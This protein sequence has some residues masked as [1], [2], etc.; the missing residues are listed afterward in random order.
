M[1]K[2]SDSPFQNAKACIGMILQRKIFSESK[3]NIALVLCGTSETDNQLAR[4]NKNEYLNISVQYNLQT[5]SWDLLQYIQNIEGTSITA[6]YIDA[7]VVAMDILAEQTK[8]QK[9]ASQ[10]ILIFSNFGEDASND[11][12]DVIIKGI[13]NS[14]MQ[15][16]IISPHNFFDDDESDDDHSTD[17]IKPVQQLKGKALIRSMLKEVQ[18]E[19]YSFSDALP[20]L[21]Y[22]QKKAVQPA[23]W[24]AMLEISSSFK[25]PITGYVKITQ[26]K[27]GKRWDTVF[28]LDPNVNIIRETS[29]HMND[30]AQT[31]IKKEDI[32]AGYRYGTT[33][34]PFSEEDKANMAYKSSEKGIKVLGFTKEDNIKYHHYIGDKVIYIVG[35]KTNES[36]E[37]ALSAFIQALYET[38]MV[39]VVR[40]VYSANSPPKLG[41][42]SPR[43]KKEYECLVF[44]QL[45][46]M[47][48]LRHYTFSSLDANAKNLPTDEQTSI[49]DKLITEMDLSIVTNDDGT[50]EEELFK[51]SQ[52]IN[53]YLQRYFQ[54]LQHRALKPE[55]SLPPMPPY[56]KNIFKVPDK[57]TDATKPI[58]EKIKKLFP[59]EEVVP[60]KSMKTG[61]S[62][63][64]NGEKSEEPPI[65]RS[66]SGSDILQGGMAE[67]VMGN[68]QEVGTV[69][70]L[71]DFKKLISNP[72]CNFSEVC[73][74]LE[75]VILKLIKD[76]VGGNLHI[77][78][79]NSVKGYRE[80][81]IKKMEPSNFNSFLRDLK[82][83]LSS[84]HKQVWQQIISEK[85]N[86]IT[87][88]ECKKSDVSTQEGEEF[89]VVTDNNKIPADNEEDEEDLLAK[90]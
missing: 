9:F 77:K 71:E 54:C 25:L 46:F 24:N 66:K 87:S 27:L 45:P 32:I 16:N 20:A 78:A 59:L 79:I 34:V 64:Q 44:I 63:F 48:D 85:I 69:T 38:S 1:C 13:R 56:I 86:L 55:S 4:A 31:E 28:A 60:A 8:N 26:Y 21:T 72:N 90:M 73:K 2:G 62:M 49:I 29:Y 70:P 88:R 10:R 80:E 19:A 39:A 41:F 65:K 7:L 61:A 23:G 83:F 57:I 74:Q 82:N 84:S 11:Q 43:I 12:I 52:T 17:Q 51:S 18:G 68:I 6:D 67:I 47:E 53:P 33:L 76:P 75:N 30:E 42:L 50:E 15:L 58:L 40:Y 22:Y 14:N 81:S 89:L 3:D 35:Q 5:A 36:V 37:K